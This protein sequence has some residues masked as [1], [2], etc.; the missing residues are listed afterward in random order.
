MSNPGGTGSTDGQSDTGSEP[1]GGTDSGSDTSTT[2]EDPVID[3]WDGSTAGSAAAC[4]PLEG[5]AAMAWVVG[6]YDGVPISDVTTCT[7]ETTDAS[8]GQQERWYC[9]IGTSVVYLGRFTTP[10]D[11]AAFLGTRHGSTT[12]SEGETLTHT[13]TGCQV[14]GYACIALSYDE[15]EFTQEVIGA[16]AAEVEAIYLALLAKT[17][18]QIAAAAPY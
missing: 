6:D 13:W 12:A 17:E 1:G 9:P 5:L 4:P 15:R 2:P 3:C 16:D 14:A 10:E 8:Y 11:A 7:E 18:S